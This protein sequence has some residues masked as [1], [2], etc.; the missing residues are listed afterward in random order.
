MSMWF[1]LN[2]QWSIVH[3]MHHE[4][5][6]GRSIITFTTVTNDKIKLEDDIDS[7]QVEV[8]DFLP[9]F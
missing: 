3:G 7:G 6:Q 5:A 9:Y 2:G 8:G 1:L 4:D